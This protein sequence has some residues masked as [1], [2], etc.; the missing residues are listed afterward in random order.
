MFGALTTLPTG[1]ISMADCKVSREEPYRGN[2]GSHVAFTDHEK[3][4]H[5]FRE[6]RTFSGFGISLL[7]NDKTPFPLYRDKEGA[8][9]VAKE[10]AEPFMVE[11]HVIG[12]DRSCD[13]WAALLQMNGAQ[14]YALPPS[15]GESAQ[16]VYEI[17]TQPAQKGATIIPGWSPAS[18]VVQPFV[19]PSFRHGEAEE[20]GHRRYGVVTCTFYSEHHPQRFV[21]PML[22]GPSLPGYV[23][24]KDGGR[25]LEA[26]SARFTVCR[27]FNYAVEIRYAPQDEIDRLKLTRVEPV[28]PVGKGDDGLVALVTPPRRS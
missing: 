15:A 28:S 19:A 10:D 14:G 4:D 2:A 27:D 13:R 18:G 6:A 21:S 3:G 11:L 12:G 20:D 9:W 5:G 22:E 8:L 26:E 7:R 24:N 16:P 23:V 25:L 17:L 1:S